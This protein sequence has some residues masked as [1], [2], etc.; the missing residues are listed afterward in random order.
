MQPAV[1][2]C[3]RTGVRKGYSQVGNFHRRRLAGAEPS[4]AFRYS[5]TGGRGYTRAARRHFGATF[6][7]LH[8]PPTRL[9]IEG[10]G[11][12]RAANRRIGVIFAKMHRPAARMNTE[13]L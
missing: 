12:I 2:P 5:A 7:G 13:R 8:H 4:S 3:I 6:A 11:Y 10:R 9:Y 1:F